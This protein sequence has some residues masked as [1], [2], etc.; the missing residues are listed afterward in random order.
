[1]QKWAPGVDTVLWNKILVITRPAH[2]ITITTSNSSLSPPTVSWKRWIIDLCGIIYATMRPYVNVLPLG[3]LPLGMKKMV[4][5]P[6]GMRITASWASMT[7]SLSNYLNHVYIYGTQCIFLYYCDIPAME[8]ITA[9]A[10]KWLNASCSVSI[11]V[12]RTDMET[13]C[14]V[15]V[16]C[17]R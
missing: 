10:S 9:L 15:M 2:C 14:P 5:F 11:C 3:N 6:F 12:D 1:M 4:L 13:V 16:F 17:R 8:S 7:R